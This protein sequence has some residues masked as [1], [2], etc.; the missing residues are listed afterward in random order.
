[1][2]PTANPEPASWPARRLAPRKE[3]AA[4]GLPRPALPDVGNTLAPVLGALGLVLGI[5]FVFVW[6]ARR[7]APAG[8]GPLPKEA[9]EPL[10]SVVLVGRQQL[11][12]LR[13]G[14]RLLLVSLAPGSVQPVAEIC[15]PA[16]VEH[17]LA[18]CRRQRPE[19]ATAAFRQMIEQAASQ[20]TSGF[21]GAARPAARGG[22]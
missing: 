15:D 7:V 20:P 5:F 4:G 18:L 16:E 14:G 8:L 11:Q 13:L 6:G 22:R 3:P 10:G 17:L 19:S 2:L 1:M 9:V 12:L 21:V